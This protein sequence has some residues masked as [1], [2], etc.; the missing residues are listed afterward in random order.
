MLNFSL[1][2]AGRIGKLHAQNIYNHPLCNLLYVFD[3]NKELAS[4]AAKIIQC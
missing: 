1:I 3:V 2:G 4:S